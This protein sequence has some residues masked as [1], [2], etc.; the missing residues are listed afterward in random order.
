MGEAVLDRCASDGEDAVGVL[1]AGVSVWV[2]L[3]MKA[4]TAWRPAG[5][6]QV[7]ER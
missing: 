1:L 5:R 4:V 3:A 2:R 7:S 6:G